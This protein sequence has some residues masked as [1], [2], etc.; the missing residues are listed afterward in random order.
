MITLFR[1]HTHG[2]YL[3]DMDLSGSAP[4]ADRAEAHLPSVRG[5]ATTLRPHPIRAVVGHTARDERLDVDGV[6]FVGSPGVGVDKIDDLHLPH[7]QVYATVAKNDAINI[8]NNPC[9]FEDPIEM[10]LDIHGPN[11]AD[12]RFG[13]KP[14]ESDPGEPSW[15]IGSEAAHSAYWDPGNRSLDNIGRIIV[16]QPTR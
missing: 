12:P 8:T 15:P 3:T 4:T 13:G 10:S 2:D 5:D 7:D 14:F 11:P 1:M 9:S 6:I 16:G